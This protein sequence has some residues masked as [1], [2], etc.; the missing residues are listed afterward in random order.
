MRGL[1]LVALFLSVSAGAAPWDN[2]PSSHDPEIAADIRSPNVDDAEAPRLLTVRLA[3]VPG[4][5]GDPRNDLDAALALLWLDMLEADG[6]TARP[7]QAAVWGSVETEHGERRI[8]AVVA[9]DTARVFLAM[10]GDFERLGGADALNIDTTAPARAPAATVA[11]K[12]VAAAPAEKAISTPL[13]PRALRP[14]PLK[15]DD[16]SNPPGWLNIGPDAYSTARGKPAE[17]H[18]FS[19]TVARAASAGAAL[20]TVYERAGLVRVETPRIEEVDKYPT[21]ASNRLFVTAGR[22][23]V[24][25]TAVA[26]IATVHHATDDGSWTVDLLYATPAVLRSWD[27]ALI[28][29]H[30]TDAL[31]D[32]RVLKPATRLA[33]SKADSSQQIDL[34]E[35]LINKRIDE[36]TTMAVGL[37]IQQQMAVN[38]QLMQFNQNLSTEADCLV[39]SGCSIEYD[40]LGQAQ[41]T[42]D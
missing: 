31:A 29:A 17:P 42:F 6:E 26:F 9:G 22:A 21:L 16:Q 33:I 5:S 40:A 2:W 27:T 13:F 11:A 15:T 10:A 18:Y 24:A 30:R 28:V 36:L 37:A 32:P 34:I 14:P 20:A 8:A 38:Q 19:V 25:G 1:C 41:M 23:R 7:G 12:P 35:Y 39:T 4:V 3:D